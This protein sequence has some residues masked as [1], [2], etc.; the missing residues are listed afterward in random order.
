ALV[1]ASLAEPD[2]TLGDYAQAAAAAGASVSPQALDQRFGPDSADC[3]RRFVAALAGHAVAGTPAALE[4][5]RRFAGVYVQDG[6][7]LP[8][9]DELAADFPGHTQPGQRASVK[10]QVRLELTVGSVTGVAL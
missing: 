8:L 7:L 2:P 3:L 1:F 9:P 5:L 4:L 6:T 10:A